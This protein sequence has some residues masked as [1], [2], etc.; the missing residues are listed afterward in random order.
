MFTQ[1]SCS[2]P[3]GLPLLNC[4]YDPCLIFVNDELCEKSHSKRTVLLWGFTEVVK[5]SLLVRKTMRCMFETMFSLLLSLFLIFTH[6]WYMSTESNLYIFRLLT[7]CIYNTREHDCMTIIYQI[8]S[9]LLSCM[10]GV[11]VLLACCL[12]SNMY[13]WFRKYMFW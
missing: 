5:S 4:K 3:T 1:R 8:M 6:L 12:L 10:I 9:S 7:I 2:L 13:I 11:C